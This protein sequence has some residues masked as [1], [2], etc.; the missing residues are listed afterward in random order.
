MRYELRVT[1]FDCLDQVHVAATLTATEDAGA[2]Q[3][4]TALQWTA[5][6]RGTGTVDP[7]AWV[8]AALLAAVE[9]L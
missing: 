8:R 4:V 2:P 7:A 1:A 5:T 6:S 3:P 9:P